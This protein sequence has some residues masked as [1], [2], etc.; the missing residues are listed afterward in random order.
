V[1]TLSLLV[2]R[3]SDL[4]RT[5][6]FYAALGLSFTREQ[7]GSGPVH[8]A[9][10][11]GEVVL[12]LYPRRDASAAHDDTRVGLRVD[13][14]AGAI[15]AAVAAGGS[16]HRAVDATGRAV[17]VDPDGRHVDLTTAQGLPGGAG[18]AI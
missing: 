16:V 3:A 9:C 2:L 8:Y 11:L 7:H 4:E 6:T 5:R 17:L 10:V 18:G 12:E 14:A 15:A 1:A 13:D